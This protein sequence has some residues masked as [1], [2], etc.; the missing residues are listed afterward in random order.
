MPASVALAALSVCLQGK[1]KVSFSPYWSEELNLYILIIAPP[2]ERK[3]AVFSAMTSPINKFVNEYNTLHLIDVQTYFNSKKML[4]TK[5]NKAIEK[6]EDGSVIRDI[7]ME[8]NALQPVKEMELITTDVTAEALAA[9]MSDNNDT[10]GILSPAGGIFDVISGM[11]S[12]S[13][14]NLNIFLSGYDG[15]PVKIDR[16][17]GSVTL[18]HPLLTFGICAQPQVLNNVISNQQFIGK[19]LTQ[20]FLFCLPDSMIEHRKL[21]YRLLNMPSNPEQYIALTCKATDLFTA[22]TDNTDKIEFQMSEN[23]A[24]ADYREFFS[25]LTDEQVRDA[26]EVLT[27]H[28]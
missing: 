17:Y 18:S 24:L 10:I 20:R 25:K 11:Y 26:L 19:E 1:A 3:S 21:I 8:I 4:D 6:G 22:Y 15:E 27:A 7:Q 13:I 14:T 23:E 2:G 9:I 16:K 12:N 5:L 28:K